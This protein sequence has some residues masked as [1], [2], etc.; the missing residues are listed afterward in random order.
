VFAK[1]AVLGALTVPF[2]ALTLSPRR[3][4]QTVRKVRRS[5]DYFRFFRGRAR[6]FV[7]RVWFNDDRNSAD[8]PTI[9]A[10][11]GVTEPLSIFAKIDIEGSEYRV[12]PFIA[13]RAKL[14]T[15]LVIEFHDTDICSAA[16]DA[17]IALLKRDFEIVH[18]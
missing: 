14:F 18:T 11:T 4:S 2:R 15:G 17:Q 8:I 6:H 3:V 10:R 13:E 1:A 5:I 16:F 9:I 7:Q 12:L